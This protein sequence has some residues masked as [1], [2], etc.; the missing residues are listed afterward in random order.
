[1]L[2]V[3]AGAIGAAIAARLSAAGRSVLVV[4]RGASWGSGT[5]EGNAGLICPS[6]AGPWA[7]SADVVQGLRWLARPDSPLAIRPLPSLAPFLARTL[8]QRPGRVAQARQLS[9]ELCRESLELHRQRALV[10]QTGF[11]RSGLLDTY[12][13]PEGFS[14]ARQAATEHRNAGVACTVLDAQQTREAE[15]ALASGVC[16]G[17][18][19]PD[20]ASCDPAAY[21]RAEAQEAEANG[22]T[23]VT[24]AEVLQIEDQGGGSRV[25]TTQGVFTAEEVVVAAGAWSRSLVHALG[26]RL[27]MQ[28]GKGYAVDLTHTSREALSRPVMLQEQ[29]IAVTPMPGRLRCAGTMEFAGLDTTMRHQR[30]GAIY[31]QA[32]ECLPECAGR[33]IERMWVGLRPCTPD[34]L[35]FIGR[36]PGRRRITVAAGHAML[37]LTLAPVTAELVG[38]LLDGNP[39][40]RLDA[41][42]VTPYRGAR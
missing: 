37:G 26:V 41:L 8:A 11:V 29:R 14:R 19:F 13:T 22:V 42:A 35:P 27:P 4:E 39:D 31:R 25:R 3:G 6:H 20:E 16:G 34:G 21:I 24:G 33:P 1:M 5:S 40:P 17:V 7:T 38:G 23:V 32:I 30:L 18:L 28:A 36:L 9:R 2:V 10:R 12:W 15:P